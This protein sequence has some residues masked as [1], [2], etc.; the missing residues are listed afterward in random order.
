MII[1]GEKINASI[2]KIKKAISGRDERLLKKMA[3]EQEKAG[4]GVIDVNV[5]TGEGTAEDEIKDMEWLVNLVKEHLNGQICIDSANPG[6]LEAGVKAGMDK[7]G[8]INSVKATKDSIAG[9]LP[10]VAQYNVSVIALAMDETGVP[11]E[12]SSRVRACEK[13]MI[14]VEKMGISPEKVFFDPLVLPVSTDASQGLVT[15]ETLR[16]I[17]KEFNPSK[18]ILALSNI[19]FGLPCRTL[20]NI[21]I[22]HMTMYFEVDALLMNPLDSCLMSAIRAGEVVL[23]KDR[24]CR[25]YTQAFRKGILN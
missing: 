18:T 13:I 9:I 21:A 19:S 5:G 23:G 15:L 22:A 12:V 3:T 6:V 2:P 10:L 4:A 7:V 20:I 1:I 25:K 8:F 16:A 17:K 11:N 14:Q 24:H